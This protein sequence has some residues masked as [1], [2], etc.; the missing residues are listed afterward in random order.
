MS[1]ISIIVPV[2]NVEKQ[3]RNCLESLVNQTIKNYE[4]IVVNDGS[5]DDSEV[6]INEYCEKYG[7]LIK[8]YS[9]ENSGVASTRNFGIEKA[10]SKYISFVDG[11]DYIDEKYVEKLLPFINENIDVIKYKLQK[12]D[13]NG[14]LIERVD[15]PVFAVKN[16]EEAFNILYGNDVLI[17]SPC[18]YAFKKLIFEEN[19]YKFERHYHEDYGLI[20]IVILSA[21]S[22]I[23]LNEYL[24]NYVQVDNSIT[25]NNDY[26]RVL[27]RVNDAMAHYDNALKVI[28]RLD[29]SGDT[30]D[31]AKIYYSNAIILKLNELNKEDRKLYSKKLKERKIYKY[32][33]AKNMKQLIKKI[34]I[35]FSVKLYLK[36]R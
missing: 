33:K 15:G 21:K 26:K 14:N 23:S 20:P 31:N 34:L 17:D 1:E 18:V 4:I 5:T 10:N 11:D 36:V 29:I 32:F 12:V 13:E 7:S 6:I 24:Y 16:A 9:K 27:D 30:K 3:I 28:D 25:R 35:R 19:K 2:Y 22:M 8:Y